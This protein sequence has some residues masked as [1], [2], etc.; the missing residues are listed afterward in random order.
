LL[1]TLAGGAANRAVILAGDT[2]HLGAR[3]RAARAVAVGRR[4]S[5]PGA[6]TRCP[7]PWRLARVLFAAA[8]HRNSS[9]A[10]GASPRS[11]ST[12]WRPLS[13]HLAVAVQ[14]E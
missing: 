10:A 9:D 14:F 6:E 2:K 4:L 13:D 3:E 12:T 11:A 5:H 8:P 7:G 1:A